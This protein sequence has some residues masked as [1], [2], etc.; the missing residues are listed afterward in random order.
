MAEPDSKCRHDRTRSFSGSNHRDTET[1]RR[2]PMRATL[3]VFSVSPCLWL[4]LSQLFIGLV[5]VQHLRITVHREPRGLPR[6]AVMGAMPHTLRHVH[7]VT[8]IG[9]EDRQRTDLVFDLA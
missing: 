7:D 5:V 6:A 1:Q 2:P 4:F 3:A 8:L 9:Q